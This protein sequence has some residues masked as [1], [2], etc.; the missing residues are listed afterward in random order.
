MAEELLFKKFGFRWE[1][2]FDPNILGYEEIHVEDESTGKKTYVK[3]SE[4]L[5]AIG[6]VL[7]EKRKK[8]FEAI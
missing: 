8:Y 1:L 3:L 2:H 5:D 6:K 4:L 7:I